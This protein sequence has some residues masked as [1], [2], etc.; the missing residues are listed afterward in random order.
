M[1]SRTSLRTL[2]IGLNAG[3]VL[4]AVIAVAVSAVGLIERFADEQGLARV[5]LAGAAAQEAVERSARDVQT[6]ALLLSER[7]TVRRMLTAGDSA[8]LTAFLERFRVTS[9]LSGVAILADGKAFAASG[10]VIPWRRVQG[11]SLQRSPGGAL[12]LGS[13]SPLREMTGASAAAV[14]VLDRPFA[15]RTSEQVGLA[16]AILA[17]ESA[18]ED[19][20]D[21]RM[22]LRAEVLASGDPGSNRL[23]ETDLF[24]SVRPLKGPSGEVLALLETSLPRAAVTASLTRLIRNLLLL[25]LVVAALA[26]LSGFL[27]SRRL[28]RPVQDL[29]ISAARIGRGDLSTPTPR[30][31]GAGAELGTLAAT[32]EDMRRRLLQLTSELRRRQAEG[33][34]ILT[35]I[36][37]GVFSVD[38]D[39]RIQYLN[40]QT[41]ALLGIRPEEAVGR[42]CGDVLR[43][44][45]RDGGRPCDESCPIVHARFRGGASATEH[46]VLADGSRR[47]V[48]ITSAAPAEDRQFQ[49]MRDETDVEAARR[50]R[51]AVLANI[52]HELRTP[53]SA[54]LASLE[55]LR[56]RLLQSGGVDPGSGRPVGRRG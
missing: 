54:Q 36:S 40:P 14:L 29:T 37:E 48:V 11:S 33:E 35:G 8:A 50:Q 55:L 44:V 24:V 45:G 32:M 46:L 39:R 47:S 41:A 16:V 30:T 38:R 10:A 1:K 43:P 4:L 17:P 22:P 28:T 18:L 51:D 26:I 34:T 20:D 19:P 13:V 23:K 56:E 49:V 53:L 2:L 5:Q 25:A 21:P 9:G 27:I 7:P 3:L 6:S 15:D 52:S 31:P 42:F 12:V